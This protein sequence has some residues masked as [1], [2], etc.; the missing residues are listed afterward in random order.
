M[1][2]DLIYR[3]TPNHVNA[4]G[5]RGDVYRALH[6]KFGYACFTTS[7]ANRALAGVEMGSGTPS[8]YLSAGVK[9]TYIEEVGPLAIW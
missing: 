7:Q 9:N 1:K 8:T 4:A 5:M 3:V 6:A 2:T